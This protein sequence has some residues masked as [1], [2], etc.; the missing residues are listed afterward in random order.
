MPAV[1][2][3]FVD[4]LGAEFSDEFV[5]EFECFGFRYWIVRDEFEEFASAVTF[6]ELYPLGWWR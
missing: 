2:D 6:I 4:F 1:S 3:Y 5:D